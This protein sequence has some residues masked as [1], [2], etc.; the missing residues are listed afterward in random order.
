VTGKEVDKD[1]TLELGKIATEAGG[2]DLTDAN[3]KAV[4]SGSAKAFTRG[5]ETA[6]NG[7]GKTNGAPTHDEII[8]VNAQL[9]GQ[10]K[11]YLDGVCYYIGR[12]KHFGNDETP[13]SQGNDTYGTPGNNLNWLGR[14]GVLRNN[15]YDLKVNSISGPGEP[16]IPDTPDTPDDDNYNYINL[17][18]KVLKWAKRG[19]E[20]HF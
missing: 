3:F 5:T 6:E 1:Y 16:V 8:K 10:I 2:H 15:W 17:S 9:N 20:L 18:V 4:A 13:W 14:Y 11:T 7:D 19:Q 12:I